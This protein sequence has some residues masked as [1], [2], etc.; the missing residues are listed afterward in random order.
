MDRWHGGCYPFHNMRHQGGATATRATCAVCL[1]GYLMLVGKK[2]AR[3]GF[4]IVTKGL[5]H[6]HLGSWHTGPCQGPRFP[7]L[8]EATDG[9]VWALAQI[10]SSIKGVTATMLTHESRPVLWWEHVL[11]GTLPRK[12]ERLE[13]SPG[14]AADYHIGRPSYDDLWKSRK[15]ELEAFLR[16]LLSD[17]TRYAKVIETWT[18]EQ[19]A[20]VATE[21]PAPVRHIQALWKNRPGME[22]PKCQRYAMR[23]PT[24]SALFADDEHPPTCLRCGR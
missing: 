9:T 2:I 13:V 5:G 7:D 21:P 24:G 19:Y 18:P 1:R 10:R 17:E 15:R 11:Y 4:R 16:A 6:G 20:R 8:G 3:H 14:A 23:P 12:T 22:S